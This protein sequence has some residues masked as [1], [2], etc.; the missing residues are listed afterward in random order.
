VLNATKEDIMNTLN[1]IL[2]AVLAIGVM[3]TNPVAAGSVSATDTDCSQPNTGR[4]HRSEGEP[5]GTVIEAIRTSVCA[6]A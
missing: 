2:A 5:E 4:I 6:S 1:T 3:G